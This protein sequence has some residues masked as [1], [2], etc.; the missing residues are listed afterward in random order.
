VSPR[1]LFDSRDKNFDKDPKKGKVAEQQK[2]VLLAASL[3][4]HSRHDVAKTRRSLSKQS[5]SDRVDQQ[6]N[7]FQFRPFDCL[8]KRFFFKRKKCL[9]R[10]RT[11]T[12]LDKRVHTQ[13][14][15]R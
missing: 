6:P 14:P 2:R 11:N 12:F 10:A 1:E 15:G 3:R 13:S 8:I 9:I 5:F 4:P 7:V